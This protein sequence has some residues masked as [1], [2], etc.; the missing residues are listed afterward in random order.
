MEPEALA[1]DRRAL[2][3]ATEVDFELP[4]LSLGPAAQTNLPNAR[5]KCRLSSHNHHFASAG[6]IVSTLPA[7][8]PYQCLYRRTA[9]IAL[10]LFGVPKA[11]ATKAN[12]P[13]NPFHCPNACKS[14]ST[15]PNSDLLSWEYKAD[16]RRWANGQV[17]DFLADREVSQGQRLSHWFTQLA[18]S[19]KS[20]TP[21]QTK[22]TK[23]N[24]YSHTHITKAQHPCVTV[25]QSWCKPLL[26]ELERLSEATN[27]QRDQ[28][29]RIRQTL[30]HIVGVQLVKHSEIF[31]ETT[32]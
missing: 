8:P 27:W 11:V 9:A 20:G 18:A 12:S 6:F 7:I 32:L 4:F 17:E 28:D 23:Q 10:I 24:K 30:T 22:Q 5:K 19:T 16:V 26:Q 21:K 2:G 1:A 3:A 13:K 14:S 25:R 31:D 29:R 15:T